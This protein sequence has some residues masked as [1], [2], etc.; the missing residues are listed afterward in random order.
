MLYLFQVYSV[1]VQQFHVLLSA[2]QGKCTVNPIHYRDFLYGLF[3]KC[4]FI[5]KR[6]SVQAGEGQRERQRIPSGLA[7]VSAEPSTG[8][9]P[10]NQTEI[11]T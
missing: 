11:I 6:E 5:F 4:L 1:V 10:T 7:T 9:K 3:K 8:L 2:H